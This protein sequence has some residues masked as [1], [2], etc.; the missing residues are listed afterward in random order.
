MTN[1]NTNTTTTG[2]PVSIHDYQ[3]VML[4]K[5]KNEY[6]QVLYGRNNLAQ[7]QNSM[8]NV[9]DQIHYLTKVHRENPEVFKKGKA[10]DLLSTLNSEIRRIERMI[11]T[12]GNVLEQSI[13]DFNHAKANYML[14]GD[15]ENRNSFAPSSV[16]LI[17]AMNST[18]AMFSAN[19]PNGTEIDCEMLDPHG[20]VPT[21][22]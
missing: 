5:V 18:R 4:E 7:K 15:T 16:K 21:I 12:I 6:Y 3:I 20:N 9:A 1:T 19:R 17:R 11:D 2:I 22:D 14:G 13:K 10:E 8:N